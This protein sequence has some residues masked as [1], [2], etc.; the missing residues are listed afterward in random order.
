[1]KAFVD[2]NVF[3]Y[4]YDRAAGSKHVRAREFVEYL[5]T[6]GRG[7]LSTQVLREHAPAAGERYVE[8]MPMFAARSIGVGGMGRAS[9][10]FGSIGA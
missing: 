4:A 6:S 1:M 10:A 7:V 2:T 5:W 9:V 3:V 8:R